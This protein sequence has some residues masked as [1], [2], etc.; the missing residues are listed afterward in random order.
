MQQ[1]LIDCG[2]PASR[3]TLDY[4][5]FRTLDSVVRSREVFQREKFT[6]MSQAFH[7]ER[8]VFIARSLGM[9]VVGYNADPVARYRGSWLRVREYL[10]RTKAVLDL[11]ILRK[12]PKFL[13]DKIDIN[14]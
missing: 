13:G 9:E 1:A 10:A 7:N 11:Y 2:V 14:I 8:A 12:Q 3:I 6:I 5:G 4:A